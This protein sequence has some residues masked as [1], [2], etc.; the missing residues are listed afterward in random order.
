MEDSTLWNRVDEIRQIF[1]EQGL[2]P[3]GY[4]TPYSGNRKSLVDPTSRKN[5]YLGTYL[6]PFSLIDHKDNT[7]Y[8]WSDVYAKEFGEVAVEPVHRHNGTEQNVSIQIIVS[9]VHSRV[10]KMTADKR[11]LENGKLR[12]L[13]KCESP[14][15][16]MT[17]GWTYHAFTGSSGNRIAKFRFDA[18]DRVVKNAVKKSMEYL[19]TFVPY[20]HSQYEQ[21]HEDY[22]ADTSAEYHAYKLAH[23]QN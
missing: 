16:Y 10:S 20:D 15:D 12:E 11:D 14:T 6:N 3:E 18:S 9:F 1:V 5:V 17:R 7:P 13:V 19:K 23:K 21:K 22:H 8:L 4:I 2:V